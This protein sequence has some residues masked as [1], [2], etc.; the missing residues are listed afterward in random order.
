MSNIKLAVFD[1]RELALSE[2][3]GIISNRLPR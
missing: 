1:L 3:A 2:A